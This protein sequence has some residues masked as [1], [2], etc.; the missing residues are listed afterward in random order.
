MGEIIPFKNI[1]I[2]KI[3]D[4]LFYEIENYLKE[5]FN[6]EI[7][8][9]GG[10]IPIFQAKQNAINLVTKKFNLTLEN[11]NEIVREIELRNL[12]KNLNP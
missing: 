12:D 4:D 7:R 10:N 3:P 8:E 6:N 1:D 2:S 11:A 9:N 5:S